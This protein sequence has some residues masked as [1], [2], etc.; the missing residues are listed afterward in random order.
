MLWIF[1]EPILKKPAKVGLFGV[2]LLPGC[3]SAWQ[4]I[5]KSKAEVMRREFLIVWVL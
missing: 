5:E 4:A 2:G 3:I 1:C